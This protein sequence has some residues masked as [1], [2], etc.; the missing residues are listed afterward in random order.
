MALKA[1]QTI[2]P[3]QSK[4]I[5][6][7]NRSGNRQQKTNGTANNN[8]TTFT[9]GGGIAG[10]L[11]DAPVVVADAITNGGFAFSFIAQD[12]CGMAMP[13]VLE[14][15][16]RRP[17]N[18]E[19]GKKEGPYNWAFARREGIREV[20][21][22][23]SAFII[24]MGILGIVKKF[25]GPANNVPVNMIKVLGSNMSEFAQNVDNS[26]LTDKVQTKRGFYRKV[27]DNML[28][29]TLGENTLPPEKL[30]E[31]LNSF[32][33]KAIE[34]E[35]AK[36]NKKS[37]FK[38]IANI[39]VEGSP[40]D[41]TE[42]FLQDIMK[43]KK[44][45]L[46]ASVN[47]TTV[48]IAYVGDNTGKSETLGFKKLLST[49]TDF[50]DDVI[51]TSKDKIKHLGNDFDAG[52]FVESFVN[53]RTGSRIATNVGM[54]LSVVGF[55]ALIP[56]LY[57]LGLKGKNPAF[58]TEEQ[59]SNTVNEPDKTKTATGKKDDGK[60]TKDVPFCGRERFFTSISDKVSSFPKLSK[61]L[62]SMEFDGASM[63]VA[64]MLTLLF[65]FCLP[66]RLINAPDK[67]DRNETLA[68][69]IPSFIS[70]LFV[71]QGISRGFSKLFSK[72]SGLALN[73]TP[74]DHNK[75]LWTKLRDYFSPASGI[76]VLDN[77]QLNS[78]YTNIHEYKDGING[79]FDFI[80][81]N[82][83]NVKKLLHL[84]EQVE[85]QAKIIV[86]KDI[87]DATSDEIREAFR[88]NNSDEAK[89]AKK[90]IEDIFK[91]SKNKFVKYAKRYN[92]AFTFLSTIVLVPSFMV[93]LARTCDRMTRN[94]RAKD[95]AL[96][97]QQ[98]APTEQKEVDK[99]NVTLTAIPSN[100][101]P[102]MNGF[103]HK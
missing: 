79:F 83:G 62:S 25:S 45:Y 102:S 40:E 64:G 18:P 3:E 97:A 63:S 72:I 47:E 43:L 37:I 91:D 30:E 48:S 84:D 57:S 11:L 88:N 71:A 93:W 66:T 38:K 4:A 69:D 19:T 58:A 87:K 22:G 95:M 35:N 76:N 46:P 33:D 101:K 77:N 14:G 7:D 70:I 1:I 5:I 90:V 21:S 81:E 85:E 73:I 52:K 96:K 16:N 36:P 51:A 13:R 78:K 27:F 8:S 92:S 2:T 29:T 99:L 9:G 53:R 10:A 6:R 86:G 56:K 23:P 65:G 94:A 49:L 42:T 68:R 98:N 32:V 55:Y 44:K 82:G 89:A 24:P 31:T 15:V 17:V 26:V 74:E 67:Y 59:M 34:I 80:S 75:N 54:W 103:L 61:L 41:L 50:S 100:F 20:L 12:F 60:K 28:R 39:K